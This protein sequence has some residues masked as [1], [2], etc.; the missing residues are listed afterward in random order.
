MRH[1][2]WHRKWFVRMWYKMGHMCSRKMK[3]ALHEWL[4][5]YFESEIPK[6]VRAELVQMGTTTMDTILKPIRAQ[7]KRRKNT[8]TWKSQI[9]TEFPLRPL[10]LT[11]DEPGIVE[12]DTVMHCGD[13]ASGIFANTLTMTDI[14]TG[15]TECMAVMGFLKDRSLELPA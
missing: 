3:A 1:S 6:N 14:K 13:S 5:F 9:R 4:P 10:G 12:V 11:V 15:W 2:N 7:Q 8:G